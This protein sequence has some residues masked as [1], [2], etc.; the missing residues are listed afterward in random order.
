[1]IATGAALALAL[2]TLPG[3]P[4]FTIQS[5]SNPVEAAEAAA[6]C[7]ADARPAPL[8]FTVTDM[9]AVTEVGAPS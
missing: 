5:P 1:M 4:S 2:L 3:I 6:A 9:K 7:D 8:D